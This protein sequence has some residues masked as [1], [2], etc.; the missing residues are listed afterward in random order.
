MDTNS[1]LKKSIER[2]NTCIQLSKSSPCFN[3]KQY[4]LNAAARNIEYAK[5]ELEDVSFRQKE[6]TLSELAKFNGKNGNPAYIAIDGIVYDVTWNPAWSGGTHFGM[7]AGKDL[8]KE[9]S[10]CHSKSILSSL[11][12]VGTL[13]QEV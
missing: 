6:F 2:I 11:N 9:F 1:K 13:K 8:T 3:L 10:T 5:S 12:Q 7:Y 4:W